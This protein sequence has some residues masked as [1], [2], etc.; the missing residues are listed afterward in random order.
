M[1]VDNLV[2]GGANSSKV[3]SLRTFQ[4]KPIIM[5]EL[6]KKYGNAYNLIDFFHSSPGRVEVMS[7]RSCSGEEKNF[8]LRNMKIGSVVSS[9]AAQAVVTLDADDFDSN[10]SYYPRVGFSVSVGSTVTG[11]TEC[12]I[13][14]IDTTA[15]PNTRF[16][17]KRYDT[18]ATGLDAHVYAGTLAAGQEWPIGASAFAVGTGG[19]TPTNVGTVPRTFNAQ[20]LKEAL[21]FDGMAMAQQKWVP[22]N[23]GQA[24]FN[25]ELSRAEFMLEAQQE[26]VCLMGQ[27][28]TANL[29]QV[30]LMDGAANVI[31]KSKGLWNWATELG[32]SIH[33]GST[34]MGVDDLDT[35]ETYMVNKG[36][37]DSIVA[38]YG[39]HLA[40]QKLMNNIN[41]KVQGTSGGLASGPYVSEIADKLYGGNT[42][43]VNTNVQVIKRSSI[44]FVLMPTPVF[45]N[46]YMMG[47]AGTLMS[48]A[49]LVVPLSQATVTIDSKKA[50]I[51][52]LRKRF[53]GQN[54]YSRERIVGQ[55]A[56]MDGFMN[57]VINTPII[58]SIDGSNT[59][60]LSD[61]CFEVYEAWKFVTV[62]RNA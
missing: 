43:A 24:F 51:P 32:G 12:R 59:H 28:N 5:A 21:G 48:D 34:G 31:G 37:Q 44:T 42:L 61:I 14:S 15:A 19:T 26:W 46:P 16:T 55:L 33:I 1:A 13:D 9:S 40:L 8:T 58:S 27:Q 3:A 54:S 2:I 7:G 30:S 52:G 18:S 41:A 49:I 35:I 60:W 29:T 45:S 23:G 4:N 57:Q 17:L 53:V 11:I 10:G 6:K 25:E 22:I 47:A 56:G 36:L 50:T 39:G 62:T 20:I 38:L